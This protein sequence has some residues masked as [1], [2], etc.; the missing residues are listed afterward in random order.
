PVLAGMIL[1]F[2]KK[3]VRGVALFT[4][5]L[6][7]QIT[8]NHIQITYYTL[9]TAIILGISY[10]VFAIREKTLKDFGKGIVFLVIGALI[11][12][13]PSSGHLMVN[14]EYLKHTMR[15]GSELSVHPQGNATSQVNEKGLDI[16]YA[17]SWSYGKGETMTLLIPDFYGGGGSDI[18]RLQDNTITVNRMKEL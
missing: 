12:V 9:I 15:G 10:F 7:L 14:Q 6:A 13:M 5:A 1:V 2:R 17:Y 4:L 16:N 11:A 3:Y 18:K 8:F